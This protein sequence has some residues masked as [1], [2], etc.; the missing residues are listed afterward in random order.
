MDAL[1]DDARDK[2]KEAKRTRMGMA[3]EQGGRPN[4]PTA[5]SRVPEAPAP[6]PTKKT[7]YE[8]VAA[9]APKRSGQATSGK[10]GRSSGRARSLAIVDV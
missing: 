1:A 4:K 3:A 9:L 7:K 8:P 5:P 2:R 6:L 10:A